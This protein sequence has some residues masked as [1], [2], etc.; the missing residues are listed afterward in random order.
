MTHPAD[1]VY[2]NG[3][4]VSKA[5]VR[6]LIR[7]LPYDFVTAANLRT[8]D[9]DNTTDCLISGVIYR[10]DSTDLVTADDGVTCIVD[11]GGRRWKRITLT[12]AGE[13]IFRQQ[14]FQAGSTANA[15]KI[16]TNGISIL[17]ATPQ[18]CLIIPNANNTTAATIQFDAQAAVAIQRWNGN[19]LQADEAVNGV[20]LL[21][22]VT[23][24]AATIY[25]SGLTA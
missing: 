12:V 3:V 20:P 18:L 11:L 1:A 14:S 2:V 25:A 16:T 9:L 5:A 13:T 17:S 21:L 19:A 4:A 6:T 8:Y 7:S 15:I 23:N 22:N 10:Y 24:T